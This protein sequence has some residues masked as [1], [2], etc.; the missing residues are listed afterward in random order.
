MLSSVAFPAL[1]YSSTLSHKR[2]DFRK[3]KKCYRTWIFSTNLLSNVS[4]SKTNW[5]RPYHNCTHVGLH[6]KYP[7]FCQTV[8]TAEFSGQIF[9]KINFM[10]INAEGGELFRADGQTDMTKLIVAFRSFANA[11][12]KVTCK[13]SLGPPWMHQQWLHTN[14]WS[15]F[16]ICL[17]SVR[18]NI[19]LTDL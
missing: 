14:E 10:K 5:A 2:H 4:H 17:F 1:H 7:L 12:R 13:L 3:K 15:T 6:L 11:P 9:E 16:K 18:K 8:M 19:V